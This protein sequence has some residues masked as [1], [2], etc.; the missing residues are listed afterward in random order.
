VRVVLRSYLPGGLCFYAKCYP[1]Q[2]CAPE[3]MACLEAQFAAFFSYLRD[4][5]VVD[6]ARYSTGYDKMAIA[7]HV[8]PEP[9]N[10]R[11]CILWHGEGHPSSRGE[12]R[13]YVALEVFPSLARAEAF[14]ET[15]AH[16]VRWLV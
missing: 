11:V 4:V 10:T 1:A 3:A 7:W 6:T 13:D 2:G 9:W 5:E 15:Y 14:L 16:P 12:E 8:D